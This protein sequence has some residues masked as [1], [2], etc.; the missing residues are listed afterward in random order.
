MTTSPQLAIEHEQSMLPRPLRLMHVVPQLGIGGMEN[1]VLNISAG[2]A[3]AG[4]D[5]RFCAVRQCELSTARLQSIA[6]RS[7]L[8]GRGAMRSSVG[9]LVRVMRA[10]RPDIVHSRNWGAI[11]AVVAARIAGVPVAI[12]SEHGYELDMLDGMP[13]R[14]RYFRRFAYRMADAVLTVTRELRDYHA[15]Q[16]WIAPERVSV[17]YN[18]VDTARFAPQ[19]AVR[20]RVRAELHIADGEILVGTVGRLVAIKDHLTLLRAAEELSARGSWLRVLLVGDGPERAR[21]EAF[22]NERPG[23][24]NRVTFAGASA[25]VPELLNAMDVFVLPSIS[26]GMSNTL[27]EAMATGLPVIATNVGG[28]PEVVED[29]VQGNLF[30]PRDVKALAEHLGRLSGPLSLRQNFGAAARRR[31]VER[32]SL[33]QMIDDYRS[34]YLGLAMRKRVFAR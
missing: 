5:Q 17:I 24:R 16:A 11:E 9:K 2:L 25:N 30:A 34:M 18:G 20:A 7:V 14:R 27:L 10:F 8:A 6:D 1:G 28:T 19:P 29:G 12:H 4:F 22:V 13:L 26:E 32:F 33:A 21:L 3:E 23:L 31:A 15:A